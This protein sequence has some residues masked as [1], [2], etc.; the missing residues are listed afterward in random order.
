[1]IFST[2]PPPPPSN[3]H[4]FTFFIFL[5]KN[6]DPTKKTRLKR[7][8]HVLRQN[9]VHTIEWIAKYKEGTGAGEADAASVNLDEK[10]DPGFNPETSLHAT[11][12]AAAATAGGAARDKH[13]A[14][15]SQQAKRTLSQE[16]QGRTSIWVTGEAPDDWIVGYIGDNKVAYSTSGLCPNSATN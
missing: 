5:E 11:K 6:P 9:M 1:M 14:G 12:A 13:S 16:V 7:G 2:Y 10:I 4:L 15:F 8:A 3:L